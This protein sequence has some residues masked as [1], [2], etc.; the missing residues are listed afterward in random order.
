ME[1]MKKI[2]VVP[3]GANTV[4][5]ENGPAFLAGILLKITVW[6]MRLLIKVM[7]EPA[8]VYA[9]GSLTF[10]AMNTQLAAAEADEPVREV[11]EDVF[12]DSGTDQ[13]EK[14]ARYQYEKKAAESDT[15]PDQPEET[16]YE[17]KVAEIEA[18]NEAENSPMYI[19]EKSTDRKT[20]NYP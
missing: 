7:G 17:K 4:E 15:N 18:A 13:Q 8:A 11:S 3:K 2:V 10:N 6:V 9:V 5:S 14:V 16:E 20:L 19:E 1:K 12:I